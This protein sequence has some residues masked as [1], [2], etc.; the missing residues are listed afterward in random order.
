MFFAKKEKVNVEQFWKEYEKKTGEMVLAKSLGCYIGGLPEQPGP[1]W[2]LAIATS[3]GFRFHHFPHEGWL[4]A[5]SR[6]SSGGEAP[7]EKTFF[8]PRDNIAAA[9][10]SVE[11]RWWKKI[12]APSSPLLRI[13]LRSGG[14]MEGDP[15]GTNGGPVLIETGLDAGAVAEALN[16]KT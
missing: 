2:G 14:G 3:G 15:P 4:M 9:E 12:L 13:S 6:I 8:I 16:G 1:L 5:L 10:L 11:K 7:K